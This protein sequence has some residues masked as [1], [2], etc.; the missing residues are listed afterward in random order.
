MK[1]TFYINI[2]STNYRA[3]HEDG[4]YIVFSLNSSENSN[5]STKDVASTLEKELI[6]KLTIQ[7]G[8]L[9]FLRTF[10]KLSNSHLNPI[11][12]L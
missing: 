11:F 10:K 6:C 5:F 12:E 4:M 1:N 2:D 8:R 3:I 9:K 7:N